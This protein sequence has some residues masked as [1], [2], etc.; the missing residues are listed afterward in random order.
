MYD[1]I[2]NL[3]KLTEKIN[4]TS[5]TSSYGYDADNRVTSVSSDI[6]SNGA[7]KSV[8]ETYTYDNYG[9][10]S[11]K[12][13]NSSILEALFYRTPT[14][15]TTAGQV[16]T[17][18]YSG[19]GYLLTNNYTYDAN[20]NI[21]AVKTT[22]NENGTSVEKTTNYTY[23]TA[24]Q[25]IREDNQAA[26]KTWTWEYDDAGNILYRKEY[27]Y[28]TG[29]LGS[30]VSTDTYTYGHNQWGDL[31]TA[32]NGAA[33]GYDSIGN[34]GNNRGWTYTWTHGREL[35]TISDGNI[36]WTNTYNADGIRT[37]RTNGSTT[38]QY[39]YNGSSLS[40]MTVG[41]N[42][43]TFAYDGSG[44]PM[45][46]VYNGAVYYYITNLQ[47]DV[48]AILDSNKNVVVEYTYDAWGNPLSTTGSMAT[49]LGVHNPLRYRGYVYDS[50][51][52]LYY[53]QSRYYD[54]AL[55]RFINADAFASTGTGLLGYNMF[56]YCNNNPVAYSDP[57]G[58]S[59]VLAIAIGA[60][61]G[62][63]IGGVVGAV[64]SKKK[65]GE[66]KVGAVAAGAVAGAVVGGL[67]GWGV[68]AASAA[69]AGAA[70]TATVAGT[71]AQAGHELYQNWQSAEQGLREAINSVADYGSRVFHVMN[72]SIRV[73][74]AYNATS[75][76]IAEAKY[77]YQSYSTFIQSEVA[78]DAY[79]LQTGAVSE[80]QW[81]FYQSQASGS[82]GGSYN[83]I[84]ALLEAGIQVFYH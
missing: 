70:S 42:T 19:S 73:V 29:T 43:L 25:L 11:G 7:T 5:I 26:N 82:I 65:T 20:G 34:M 18:K 54:P 69:S 45:A 83:L 46:V 84:Q 49:T 67:A 24:N 40:Q 36:T 23:D 51:T 47:G 52:Q 62:A 77:G 81:H 41:G 56:A 66:V 38:Y 37:K 48:V 55:G 17:Q 28:T 59:I 72:G 53:L 16:A 60:A 57:A 39:V 68:G 78:R 30:V 63:V 12:W 6:T 71:I 3:S 4:G 80:V 1:L 31:L 32:Y 50:E 64:A 75:N 15:T 27:A 21:T 22:T 2:N 13:V 61:I 76:I 58:Q 33:T 8:S 10:I 79:L 44:S 9:R 14:A 35:A 74:D